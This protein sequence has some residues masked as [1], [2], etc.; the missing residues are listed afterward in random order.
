MEHGRL[1]VEIHPQ[2][3]PI[4]VGVIDEERRFRKLGA[5]V[6]ARGNGVILRPRRDIRN[7]GTAVRA[8]ADAIAISIGEQGIGAAGEFR[9]IVQSIIIRI[10]VVG[11]GASED[12]LGVVPSIGIG[13]KSAVVEE[14]IQ[15]E[16]G[17]LTIR[18]PV[19]VIV[20]GAW[21]DVQRDAGESEGG[22]PT[23]PCDNKQR[24]RIGCCEG[25]NQGGTCGSGGV[26]I[27]VLRGFNGQ[28][29]EGDLVRPE[30]GLEIGAGGDALTGD[31]FETGGRAHCGESG[32]GEGDQLACW[33][34]WHPARVLPRIAC[35]IC[36]AGFEAE[37]LQLTGSKGTG[38]PQRE[39]GISAIGRNGEGTRKFQVG[40]SEGLWFHGLVETQHGLRPERL[41]ACSIDRGEAGQLG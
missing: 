40:G 16:V 35:G 29:G 17:F 33:I 3:V 13:I 9:A 6:G 38:R 34:H 20:P 26:G 1:E 15:P 14:G 11:I 2:L 18:D 19:A 5:F 12:F 28:R 41:R 22:P 10:R 25:Q 36:Q 8:V 27:D 32:G 31:D 23:A 24:F 7:Q 21:A 37:T 30:A 4:R 39:A